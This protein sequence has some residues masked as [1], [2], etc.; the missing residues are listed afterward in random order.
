MTALETAIV[1]AIITNRLIDFGA[2]FSTWARGAARF[3]WAKSA[4]I[5]LG[6]VLVYLCALNLFPVLAPAAG[7]MFTAIVIAGV[8]NFIADFLQAFGRFAKALAG[9]MTENKDLLSDKGGV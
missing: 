6:V 9:W 4:S 3:P 8:A 5:A 7:R 1:L 2:A